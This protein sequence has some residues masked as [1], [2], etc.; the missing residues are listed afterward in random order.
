MVG[1]ALRRRVDELNDRVNH[2]IE[3]DVED[4]DDPAT[5]AILHASVE[6]NIATILHMLINKIALDRAEAATAAR[7]YAVRLARQGTPSIALR[8]AY[9]F[10]AD[11]LL[12]V[13]F[14]EVRKLDVDEDL[15]WQLLRH[16]S[17]WS[18]GYIDR[19]SRLVLEDYEAEH[20]RLMRRRTSLRVSSVEELLSGERPTEFTQHT[21]Y[22]LERVHVAAIVFPASGA[23][24]DRRVTVDDE[25]IEVLTSILDADR[26]LIVPDDRSG[27][28]AWFACRRP[29]EHLDH[30]ALRSALEPGSRM[31]IAL[32]EPRAGVAGFRRSHHEARA[33][34]LVLETGPTDRLL[35]G[36]GEPGV[37]PT[38]MLLHDPVRLGA[39]MRGVLGGLAAD[40]RRIDGL[41]ET[42]RVV[43]EEQGNHQAAATR[44]M[45]HRNSI[46]Y[47]VRQAEKA[48]GRPI[49]VGRLE[50]ELA[51]QIV[52]LL[53][54]AAFADTDGGIDRN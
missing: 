26:P 50:L 24:T 23:R 52:R 31:R 12:T 44:L 36:G 21:G 28:W 25:T 43:F 49:D 4:L 7:E 11:M 27:V 30:D 53:G 46:R 22:A 18:N 35:L 41:R 37:M 5:L 33:A 47:R 14:E 16:L 20:D 34:R 9:H 54:P 51:L 48:R 40:G 3:S 2:A 13:I 8:R 29:P 6:S 42:L 15:R 10:G 19:I 45:M 1:L 17:S 38:S 32:G 39:W